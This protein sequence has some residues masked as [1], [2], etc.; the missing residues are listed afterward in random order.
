MVVEF[1]FVMLNVFVK[2][3]NFGFIIIIGFEEIEVKMMVIYWNIE[4]QT[5]SAHQM[6]IF[7]IILLLLFRDKRNIKE[8]DES[9]DKLY[10][11]YRENTKIIV[12]IIKFEG[13]LLEYNN[14]I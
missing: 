9:F 11:G 5:Y 10:E 2:R 3:K 13:D 14:S 1:E 7:Y 6:I 4:H 12:V 8:I